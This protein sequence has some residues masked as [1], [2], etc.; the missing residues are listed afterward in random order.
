MSFAHRTRPVAVATA[1]TVLALTAGC[2][3]SSGDQ[4][5]A[6]AAPPAA[7]GDN[8]AAA[9]CPST[10]VIQA[11]WFPT[12]DIAV[13]FQLMGDDYKVDVAKKRVSGSLV[14]KGKDTGVD[15]EFRSGGPAV[16]FQNGPAVAYQDK[17]INLVLA[18]LDEIIA[19]S[20]KAPMQA[21]VAPM[22][23]DPQAVIYDPAQH[24]DWNTLADVGQTDTKVLYNNSSRA[25]FAYLVGSGILRPNQISPTYDGSPSQFVQARGKIAVQGYAT[26]E[27]GVYESLPQWHK[28]VGYFLIQDSGYPDYAGVLA[29]RPADKEKLAP[30][31]QKLVPIVQQAQIDLMANPSP[32]ADKIVKSVADFH[33]IF[34][35]PAPNATFGMCQISREGLVSNPHGGPL[36]TLEPAKVSRI[37]AVLKPILAAQH[38]NV[39]A[40]LTADKLATNEFLDGSKLLPTAQPS[41]AASCPSRG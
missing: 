41:W 8:L 6:S 1:V 22:N 15:I 37:L 21:V 13:P 27:V 7:A 31:L 10:I 33:S 26:N 18:N 5:Q 28:P 4:Q 30:C 14:V 11:G 24:Q 3:S 32:A 20:D 9:G 39:P 19:G 25:A 2:N 35:Y 40:D 29:I 17:S 34:Q 16:G 36:G 23:G 38:T 12:M